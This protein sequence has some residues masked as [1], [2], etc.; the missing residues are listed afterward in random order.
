MRVCCPFFA[1]TVSFETKESSPTAVSR[2]LQ[3]PLTKKLPESSWSPGS[4]LISSASPVM[5]DS[6]TWHDPSTTSASAKIWLPF[7]KITISS[8]TV[9]A[10][11]KVNGS[12]LRMTVAFGAERMER[13]SSVF[14]DLSSCTMPMPVL[15]KTMKRNVKFRQDPTAISAAARIKNTRLK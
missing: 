7:W 4:F 9:R 12:P 5:R 8:R 2:A 15:A 13:L 1:S 10:V 3:L 14:F 6:L 11:S